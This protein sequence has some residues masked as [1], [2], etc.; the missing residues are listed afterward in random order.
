M[1]GVED[2]CGPVSAGEGG[3]GGGGGSLHQQQQQPPPI[4]AAVVTVAA[5]CQ[6]VHYS[7]LGVDS[8]G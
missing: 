4:I 7:R 5:T 1:G 3:G 2:L 8:G 6:G